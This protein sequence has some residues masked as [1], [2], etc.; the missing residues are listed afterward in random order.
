MMLTDLMPEDVM[1][2]FGERLEALNAFAFLVIS[3]HA[4]LSEVM[5]LHLAHGIRAISHDWS[6][7]RNAMLAWIDEEVERRKA[8]VAS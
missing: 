4:H 6:E 2:D 7:G 5:D 1:V 8:Q 3:N